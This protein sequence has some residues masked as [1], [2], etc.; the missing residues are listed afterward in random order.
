MK[1]TKTILHTLLVLA[2]F[3]VQGLPLRAVETMYDPQQ[4][5]YEI[6]TKTDT[7]PGYAIVVEYKGTAEEIV[8]PDKVTYAGVD[9]PVIKI[10]Q[11]TFVNDGKFTPSVKRITLSATLEQCQLSTSGY[12]VGVTGISENT[13]PNLEDIYIIQKNAR[14]IGIDN[15]VSQTGHT[16]NITG[17]W[18]YFP[19]GKV[20]IHV[21]HDLLFAL[22]YTPTDYYSKEDEAPYSLL[23]YYQSFPEK[24]VWDGTVDTAT[25][26]LVT[27]PIVDNN[28]QVVGSIDVAYIITDLAAGTAALCLP[29]K[30]Y[31]F[32]PEYITTGGHYYDDAFLNPKGEAGNITI[33]EK[34]TAPDGSV[35]TVTQVG[36]STG[37][38]FNSHITGIEFPATVVDLGDNAS[39]TVYSGT[40]TLQSL[41]FAEG[42]NLKNIGEHALRD[43]T[44]LK[45]LSLPLTIE[46][47][48]YNAFANSVLP[49]FKLGDYTALR[50]IGEYAFYSSIDTCGLQGAQTLPPLIK[51]IPQRMCEGNRMLTSFTFPDGVIKIGDEAFQYCYNLAERLD[52]PASIDTIGHNAFGYCSNIKD[53]WVWSKNTENFIW[54]F[55]YN[56][57]LYELGITNSSHSD[58]KIHF[59]WKTYEQAKNGKDKSGLLLQWYRWGCLEPWTEERLIID[60]TEVTYATKDDIFGDGVSRGSSRYPRPSA[61]FDYATHTLTLDGMSYNGG[62]NTDIQDL[63]INLKD[64]TSLGA[65][66][67]G[68][69][70]TLSIGGYSSAW[71]TINGGTAA[72]IN[73]FDN[74]VLNDD[75][76]YL[77]PIVTEPDGATYT[78]CKLSLNTTEI[79]VPKSL[80]LEVGD[81]V[82][83]KKNAA[84]ILGDGRA[85]LDLSTWTLTLNY[86]NLTEETSSTYCGIKI[87]TPQPLTVNLVGENSL[88]GSTFGVRTESTD[89][90]FKSADGTGKVKIHGFEQGISIENA[91]INIENCQVQVKG[92][93]PMIGQIESV[94]NEET[95]QYES[96]GKGILTVTDATLTLGEENTYSPAMEGMESLV[97]NNT[98]IKTPK[99][100]IFL[101]Y[102]ANRADYN[103]C[104]SNILYQTEGNGGMLIGSKRLPKNETEMQYT[105]ASFVM[106][107]PHTP[108]KLNLN[109]NCD[110]RVEVVNESV[111][112]L[113]ELANSPNRYKF[114][115]AYLQSNGGSELKYTWTSDNEN[116]ATIDADGNVNII[117]LGT[118][119]IT[120]RYDG[121]DDWLPETAQYTIEVV[122][123]EIATTDDETTITFNYNDYTTYNYETGEQEPVDLSNTTVNNTYFCVDNVSNTESPNGFFDQEEECIVLNTQTNEEQMQTACNAELGSPELTDN[124]NGLVILLQAGTGS[125][126]VNTQNLGSSQLAI[127]IGTNNPTLAYQSER[128]DVT[129]EYSVNSDTY[130]YIYAAPSNTTASQRTF[131]AAANSVKIYSIR[132]SPTGFLLDVSKTNYTTYFNS[133]AVQLPSGVKAAVVTGVQAG[134]LCID[135]RYDGDNTEA[136]IVPGGT[137]VLISAASNKYMLQILSDNTDPAPSDN[138]LRGSDDEEWTWGGDFYY[139]LS[140]SKDNNHFGFFWATPNGSAFVCPA[141][142]AYLA[143]TQSQAESSDGF[144]LEN[145]TGLTTRIAAENKQ[146][147]I[148]DIHGRR[149]SPSAVLSRGIYIIN[150]KKIFIK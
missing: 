107:A 114:T 95:S 98:K 131:V 130:L 143:L 24:I 62:I 136:N 29:H 82:V 34:V 46:S 106:I 88:F 148:Y 60:T 127:Q 47:I 93:M 146:S 132:I 137:A 7:D 86:I 109:F 35:L 25:R 2:A 96:N 81:V 1:K 23:G 69:G 92:M 18:F 149:I 119:T 64:N 134:S 75:Y 79:G 94:W 133:R 27:T 97:L 77:N 141:H 123:P 140:F 12:G 108:S 126:T 49:G 150:G 14:A 101:A 26:F 120:V 43:L 52:I 99:G 22:Q 55:S 56:Y 28:K 85:K 110:E 104:R 103:W 57:G 105:D 102:S 66:I 45:T 116:V 20:K 59:Y 32:L 72:A 11:F 44:T 9:Y 10:D 58:T 122:A 37:F 36:Q 70:G 30:N 125:I 4:L 139:K 117:G 87:Y 63:T 40:T 51:A 138:L 39:Q 41:T 113:K 54:N 111:P 5:K 135:Y 144:E 17:Y 91:N 83:F 8:I 50:N 48:G 115:G 142:T 15:F 71:L 147:V 33:P 6:Y 74:V 53:V 128:G 38:A 31:P 13:L 78:D 67:T 3:L 145:V 89:V 42:S 73:G 129:V 80:G 76:T 68:T 84:D 112:Y 124:F 90:T 61:T 100:G 121:D 118:A 19:S 21:S 65:P 16:R